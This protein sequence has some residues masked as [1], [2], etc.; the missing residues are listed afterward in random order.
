MIHSGL[1]CHAE[2][3]FSEC[4]VPPEGTGNIGRVLPSYC[5]TESSAPIED[6]AR[7]VELKRMGIL[8]KFAGYFQ[9]IC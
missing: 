4:V 8:Q 3:W 1:Q 5:L 7:A 2:I 6:D 9:L